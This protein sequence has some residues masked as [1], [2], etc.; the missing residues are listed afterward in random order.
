M[1]IWRTAEGVRLQSRAGRDVTSW[2]SDLA[3]PAMKFRPGTVVD[4]KAVLYVGRRI[5]VSAAQPHRPGPGVDGRTALSQTASSRRT[6]P[7]NARP[8]AARS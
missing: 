1:A 3:A 4:G 2:S 7:P 8:V 6:S 5:D